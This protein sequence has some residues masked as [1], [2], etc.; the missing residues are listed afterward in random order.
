MSTKQKVYT[1]NSLLCTQHMCIVHHIRFVVWGDL[2]IYIKI[3]WKN[4]DQLRLILL[5]KHFLNKVRRS[6]CFISNPYQWPSSAMVPGW[7]NKIR[8]VGTPGIHEIFRT[9]QPHSRGLKTIQMDSTHSN[10]H[11]MTGNFVF[12]NFLLKCI[13]ITTYLV[14][15]R[16]HYK[17]FRPSL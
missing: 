17:I 15:K 9:R 6:R 8:F 3:F 5:T 7:V 1:K 11:K 14:K 2:Y 13:H 10:V 12:D 4:I 16:D